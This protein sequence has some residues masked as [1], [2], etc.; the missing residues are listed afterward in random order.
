MLQIHGLLDNSNSWY[1]SIQNFDMF[2]KYYQMIK[3][4]NW[5]ICKETLMKENVNTLKVISVLKCIHDKILC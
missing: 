4:M 1:K 3:Q 2:T 5:W